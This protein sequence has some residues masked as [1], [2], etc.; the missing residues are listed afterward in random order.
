MQLV[1]FIITVLVLVSIHE[2]GHFLV[3]KLLGM[4]VLRFSIGFGKAFARFHDK[5][6]TE[7]VLAWIPLGGY[8]KLL[9]EREV[10]VPKNE[11]HLAF[12]R[13]PLWA[14]TLVV[15]AGPATNF[16]F[17]ILVFWLMFMVGI[18]SLRPIVGSVVANSIAAKAGLQ[19]GD[20][21]IRVD[22]TATP[23]LQKVMIAVVE[24]LGEKTVMTFETINP[25]TRKIAV[26]QLDLK[27]WT[28]S[29]LNPAPLTSLGIQPVRPEIPPIIAVI[30]S[31]SPAKFAGFRPNDHILA[32]NDQPI[33]D[34]YQFV[35]YIHL[36]PG[37]SVKIT[38]KRENKILVSQ[39]TIGKKISLGFQSSGYLGV[40]PKPV[41]F[42]S[43]ILL[44][45]KYPPLA[46]LKNGVIETW[47]LTLF[48]FIILKKMILGQVSL[49]SLGGPITIFESANTAL[50]Q[51]IGVFLGF[52]A[53]ISVMLA[54]IN[55]LPIPGLDGGHLLNNLIE[56]VLQRPLSLRYE[57]I[58][59]QIGMFIL[60]MLMLLATFNDILR[61]LS[62]LQS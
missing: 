19:S 59:V 47:Q 16:L 21:V 5:K 1:A 45:R 3:A 28:V 42:Q 11:K 34:W 52:L 56:F 46:A 40:Q 49:G 60:I 48:N 9:D 41:T 24:R 57:I 26:H 58:S 12:N 20:E 30:E 6:G 18:Q 32:I 55:V 13:Q 25:R 8:V 54:F 17:A 2:A 36:H 43:N 38:F 10:I 35:E 44:M 53:I 4:K 51:G 23:S 62:A 33:K 37:K 15:I 7:Y 31:N 22:N 29:P 50:Q 27:N 14:R 39:L 61:L